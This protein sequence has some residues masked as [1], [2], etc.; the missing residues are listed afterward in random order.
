MEAILQRLT[1]DNGEP[2]S[3][4]QKARN[5][6]KEILDWV[7]ARKWRRKGRKIYNIKTSE[8]HEL[9]EKVSGFKWNFSRLGNGY[10]CCVEEC[11]RGR[12]WGH[13]TC[14]KHVGDEMRYF[15]PVDEYG[16]T[17]WSHRS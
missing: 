7:F 4:P 11:R 15:R 2:Q 5:M 1:Y 10:R 16:H 9:A 14:E 6:I 12:L 13:W 8:F 17:F 3:Y